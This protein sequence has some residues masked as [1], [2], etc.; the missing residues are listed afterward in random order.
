MALKGLGSTW[1]AELPMTLTLPR[2]RPRLFRGRTFGDK[3]P[4]AAIAATFPACAPAASA[5]ATAADVPGKR[6]LEVAGP[7][8]REPRGR[9]RLRAEPRRFILR[10]DT[11]SGVSRETSALWPECSSRSI[12]A[13]SSS[14]PARKEL[15]DCF[16]NKNN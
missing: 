16:G 13:S 6:P 8:D 10:L 4:K 12:D 15:I 3:L 5:A 7:R 11:E 2:P 1:F 14:L 9:P